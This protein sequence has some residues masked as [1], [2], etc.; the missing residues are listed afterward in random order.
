MRIVNIIIT[1]F[2]LF[3]C[4]NTKINNSDLILIPV[5]FEQKETSFPLTDIAEDITAIELE[6]SDERILNIEKI[7]RVL[8]HDDYIILSSLD[9]V[10][11]YGIDGKFVCTIG[12]RGQ[13]P[14]E[15]NSASNITIDKKNNILYMNSLSQIIC[16]DLNENKYLRRSKL[17]KDKGITIY[18]MNYANDELLIVGEKR[19]F[20]EAH[21]QLDIY[22]LND[23]LQLMDSC[24]IRDIYYKSN[25]FFTNTNSNF[26]NVDS[27]VY[28]YYPEY[29]RKD[30]NISEK[31]LYD[32]LYRVEN[33]QLIPE[34][35]LNIKNNNRWIADEKFDINNIYRSSRYVFV[36]YFNKKSSVYCYDIETGKTYN[37]L[38]FEPDKSKYYPIDNNPEFLYLL[39]SNIN[40]DDLEEPNPTLFLIKLKKAE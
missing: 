22:R 35:K 27:I 36:D 15:Y 20:K 2:L 5:D 17:F 9:D 12:S 31:V 21:K 4:K 19:D 13:G 39:N 33:G 24:T 16:Y 32:T 6:F 40:P 11:L 14:Q 28:F 26:S 23:E 29:Y 38:T 7:H 1:C 8:L 34:M 37:D 25:V 18:G 3:S 10:F 30:V